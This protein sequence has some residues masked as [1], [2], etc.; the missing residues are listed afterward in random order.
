MLSFPTALFFI[1]F[2]LFWTDLSLLYSFENSAYTSSLCVIPSS[3]SNLLVNYLAERYVY[4]GSL[5]TGLTA[6]LTTDGKTYVVTQNYSSSKI[7]VYYFP[8]TTSKNGIG[9]MKLN[10]QN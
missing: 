2:Y 9:L 5:T 8:K 10:L 6:R 1:L 3:Q 7:Y 4:F